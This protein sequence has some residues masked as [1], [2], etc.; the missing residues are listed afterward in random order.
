MSV[1]LARFCLTLFARWRV[2][3]KEA[4]LPQ[5]PLLV[6][7]NHLSNADPPVLM[8]SLSRRLNIL[9][10]RELF[11][12]KPASLL[13]YSIG[14]FPVNPSKDVAAIRWAMDSL[15]HDRALLAFPEGSRSPNA[16]LQQGK[17]GVGYLA[18]HTQA[19]ILPVA[20]TGTEKI[21][22]YWRVAFPF[23]SINVSI[24]QPFTLPAIDGKLTSQL[25]QHL[26]DMIMQRIADL[27]PPEYRGYYG[28][29]NGEMVSED[30]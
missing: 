4:V 5:G 13:L 25:L 6:V 23:C 28:A 27:L 3:G 17:P 30:V 9:A 14:A 2:E 19:P 24:G 18:L 21:P 1:A 26:T 22:G 20:I 15:N 12:F 16:R 11:H 7:S 8:A 10:K 29:A